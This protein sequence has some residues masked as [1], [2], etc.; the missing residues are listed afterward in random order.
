MEEVEG[1]A[2]ADAHL[3]EEEIQI[4]QK[5]IKFLHNRVSQHLSHVIRICVSITITRHTFLPDCVNVINHIISLS[6]VSVE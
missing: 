3:L 5:T 6:N 2:C 4:Q 1:W